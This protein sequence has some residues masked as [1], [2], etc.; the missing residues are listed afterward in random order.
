MGFGIGLTAIGAIGALTS[1]YGLFKLSPPGRH[2]PALRSARDEQ[3]R[4]GSNLDGGA[5]LL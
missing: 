2:E 3:Y 1:G 5:L 4:E